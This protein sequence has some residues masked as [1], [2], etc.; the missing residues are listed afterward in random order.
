MAEIALV[1][2]SA[3]SV[4][5]ARAIVPAYRSKYSKH[6][7]TQPQL[8]VILCLMRYE[9]WTFREAEVRLAEH[10][11]LREALGLQKLPDYSCGGYRPYRLGR[12]LSNPVNAA[13]R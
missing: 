5:V 9:D 4:D 7:F 10:R 6:T 3:V 8:L 12:E 13:I 1:Q 11:E 2:F